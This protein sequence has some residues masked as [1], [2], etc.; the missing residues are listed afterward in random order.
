MF[1][2]SVLSKPL[3]ADHAHLRIKPPPIVDVLASDVERVVSVP[4]AINEKLVNS[5]ASI[6]LEIPELTSIVKDVPELE[7]VR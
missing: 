4:F 1:A 2:I 6:A 3:E 7:D 5:S